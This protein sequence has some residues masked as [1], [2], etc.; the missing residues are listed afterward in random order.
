[1]D[2]KIKDSAVINEANLLSEKERPLLV[3][4]YRALLRAAGELGA[5]GALRSD[6]RRRMADGMERGLFERDKFGNSSLRRSLLTAAAVC[7]RISP[8]R[9]MVLAVLLYRLCKAEALTIGEI[10]RKSVV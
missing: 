8:D 3:A 4:D 10:D 1:M 7:E 2:E 5:D 9:N 6:I